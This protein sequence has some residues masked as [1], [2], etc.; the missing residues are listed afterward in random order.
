MSDFLPYQWVST[1]EGKNL[2]LWYQFFPLRVDIS[3]GA[4][5]KGKKTGKPENCKKW[6]Q[7]VPYAPSPIKILPLLWFLSPQTCPPSLT[8]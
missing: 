1:L 2:V 6:W 8:F 5:C 7:N 3:K 4:F